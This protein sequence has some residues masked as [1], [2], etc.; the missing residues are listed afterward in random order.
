MR[1][2]EKVKI[3]FV[4]TNGLGCQQAFSIPQLNFQKIIR[5]GETSTAE[6]VMPKESGDIAF[7][8]SMGMYTG[9]IHVI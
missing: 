8:C 1:A 3:T 7:T 9:V 4:N 2:G 5:V 6:V